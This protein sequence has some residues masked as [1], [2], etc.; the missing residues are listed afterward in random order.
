[1]N[2]PGVWILGD[3]D[4]DDRHHGMGI[5][6]E[7][8]TQKGKGQ[9][10]KPDSSH[11]NYLRFA[12]AEASVPVPDET[13]EMTFAKDNAAEEGFNRWTINGKAYPMIG[14]IAPASF[15]LKEGKRYRI[16]MRNA[17]DDIHPIYHRR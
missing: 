3:L 1:M 6:V 4:D 9:S 15:Q 8:A 5:V 10:L 13:V 11:W 2:H 7:Y 16:R 12:K 14:E 17:S